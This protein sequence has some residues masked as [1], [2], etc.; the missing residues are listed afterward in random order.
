MEKNKIFFLDAYALIFRAYYAF[1]S[2][3][4]RNSKGMNTSAVFGFVNTLDE[5][6]RKENPTHIAV[7]FD[8]PSPTFRNEMYA[9]YK[10]NRDET[11]EDIKLSVPYIKKIIEAYR[12]PVIEVAGYEADDVIGTLAKKMQS[13]SN[14]VYMM[15]PDKDYSQL[16]DKNIYIFKPRRSGNDAEV[17]GVKE[18]LEKF[19]ITHPL[20]V[21]DIMALWGDASDNVPG[22]PGIG[23]KTAKKIISEYKSVENIYDHLD[24]FK[25]KQKENIINFKEQILLSK[26]LVTIKTDVP[27]DVKNL[28]LTVQSPDIQ[29]LKSLFDE[30]EFQTLSK[31]LLG[32]E[33]VAIAKEKPSQG[34]LFDVNE[35]EEVS[36]FQENESNNIHTVNHSY[37]LVESVSELD[38]LAVKLKSCNTVCFD[39][40]TTGLDVTIAELVGL[41]FCIKKNEA[42]YVPF[43]PD[44]EACIKI[45]SYFKD[46]LENE[47]ITKV[48]HNIKYDIQVLY[49]YDIHTKGEIFDTMVAHY[50]IKPDGKHKLD[51]LAVEYFRYTMVPIEDLIGKK[52]KN[53]LTMRDV[54][55][56]TTKEYACEDADLTWQL[57]EILSKDIVKLNLDYLSRTVEMPLIHVL[58]DM[59]LAGFRMDTDALANYSQVLSKEIKTIED[60]IYHLAGEK[61]NIASPKQLG[62]ILFEKLK[63]TDKVQKTKTKQYSTSEETLMKIRDKHEIISNILDYRTLTKLLSTYVDALPKLINPKTNRIHTSFNQTIA[64]TGRLSSINPNLQ[65]I[66][67]RDERGREIRKS[68][69]PKNEDYILL[70]ADYSQIELR[71]MAHLSKDDHMMEAFNRGVDIHQSTAAKINKIKPEEV[72]KEMRYQAKTANFGIIYGISAFGLSQRLGISR[73]DAKTLI[74]NYFYTFPKVREYM[75]KSIENAKK[76]GYVETIYGR[77]R[78]LPDIHSA[79]AVVRGFA[80]R[81]AINSPLQGSA[82]DIIKHAMVNIFNAIHGKFKTK[83]ILQVHDELIFDVYKPELEEIKGIVKSYM[84]GVINLDVPLIVDIGTGQNW[85]ESH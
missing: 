20:Q 61:F 25:G 31:R 34:T 82:A 5:L 19:E 62:T 40:E 24:D 59:E 63:I 74:D 6:L 21:I 70:A 67:V 85:L 54:E 72:T 46:V 17:L 84:E 76:N 36:D 12:I 14:E 3:P 75:N 26:E 44:K 56:E 60:K 32:G 8:P 77:K 30:L 51:A 66:P 49:N 64:A 57:Y 78:Y 47:S 79:N 11:P 15:T 43:P 1:I 50:L 16:V 9:E 55:V 39:T 69:I 27:I 41:A 42:F 53:Q 10:A 45:L 18:I 58:V 2:R 23:E 65:N 80:E 38:S 7:V 73:T 68:F 48:G 35:D 33:Q 29:K 13:D 83:M 52:G 28:D 37:Y 22:A 71:L 4:I 81:N